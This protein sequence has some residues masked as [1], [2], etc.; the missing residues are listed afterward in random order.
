MAFT[1]PARTHHHMNP[2]LMRII[3]ATI[4]LLLSL[5]LIN[6]MQSA[7]RER[8]VP[9]PAVAVQP[10]VYFTKV[11]GM[12]SITEPVARQIGSMAQAPM[13]EATLRE[14]LKG[15]TAEEKAQ[16]FYTEIPKGTRLLGL[17]HA[18]NTITVNLSREF[19]EGGGATTIIQRVAELRRTVQG[20]E[21]GHII[22]IAIEGQSA[23]TL[24]SDGLELE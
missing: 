21:P 19:A 15:P 20:I 22:E 4:L 2:E 12:T 18:G 24:G 11:Q 8:T 7:S 9:A 5:M 14:L 13:L 16:G 17:Y 1:H 23:T 10:Q 3:I 6:M